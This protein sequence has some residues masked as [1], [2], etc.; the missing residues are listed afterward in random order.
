[1]KAKC[2]NKCPSCKEPVTDT[3][4]GVCN[5]CYMLSTSKWIDKW[6]ALKAQLKVSNGFAKS[7]TQYKLY[8]EA[9]MGTNEIPDTYEKW[10]AA[11]NELAADLEE[12][13]AQQPKKPYNPYPLADSSTVV[14]NRDLRA[15]ER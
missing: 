4:V 2:G 8:V 11:V 15:G 10:N 14:D 1:M 6:F 13:L 3:I 7:L 12:A 9:R 5:N